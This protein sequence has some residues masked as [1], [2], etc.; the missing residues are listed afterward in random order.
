MGLTWPSIPYCSLAAAHTIFAICANFLYSGLFCLRSPY[1]QS[2]M[3]LRSIPQAVYNVVLLIFMPV[4]LHRLRYIS[5]AFQRVRGLSRSTVLR[6]ARIVV[7][8]F[9]TASVLP[10][11][12]ISSVGAGVFASSNARGGFFIS[13]EG[14]SK[15]T[16]PLSSKMSPILGL[17]VPT[18][19]PG[20]GMYP[21][22]FFDPL[23]LPNIQSLVHMPNVLQNQEN[24]E[25]GNLQL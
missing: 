11:T 12:G 20:G 6:M 13:S 4:L 22:L 5:I 21:G 10:G 15:M 3:L 24:Q 8:I 1:S 2:C 25:K 18:G 9:G 23:G 17:V 7:I 14:G 19:L 16:P